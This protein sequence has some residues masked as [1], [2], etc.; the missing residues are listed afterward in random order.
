VSYPVRSAVSGLWREKWIN[1][2]SVLTIASGL[3]LISVAFL[4]VFNLSA[5]V[6]DLPERFSM[7]A[8]LEDGLSAE[9]MQKIVTDTRA[10]PGVRSARFISREEAL[11]ELRVTLEDSGQVLEGLDENPLPASVE[12][13]VKESA[14]TVERAGELARRMEALE[15]VEDVQYGER[16]LSI[17]QSV[18]R[19]TETLGALLVGVLAAGMVFVCYSTV[20]ILFYRKRAEIDTIKLLGATKGFIRAPFLIEGG[21]LGAAGGGV[22]VLGLLALY[23]SL[24]LKLAG[25]FPLLKAL[26]LPGW[27][28]LYP[29]ALGLAIG[30]A[31]AYIAIGRIRF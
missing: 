15:G 30:V 11:R 5:A 24:Y 22:S 2:L 20:K 21:V 19:Y 12:V 10:M 26:V 18:R 13:K 1:L 14:V 29:P 17:I 31:G 7:M 8:F 3:F 27:F 28:L 9:R 23:S 6:R 25:S 16:V 4:L